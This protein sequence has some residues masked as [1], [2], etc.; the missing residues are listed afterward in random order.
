MLSMKHVLNNFY[1]AKGQRLSTA[2]NVLMDMNS[3]FIVG[4][5]LCECKSYNI[6]SH[7][8]IIIIDNLFISML[9]SA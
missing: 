5:V 6:A 9:L 8:P 7:Q 1:Y 4:L 2:N 3:I